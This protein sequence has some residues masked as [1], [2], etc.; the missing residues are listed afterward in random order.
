MTEIDRIHDK[1]FK[2]TFSNPDNVRTFLNAA[3]PESIRKAIDFSNIEIDFTDYV[4]QRFK[5][6]FSDM[7]ARTTMT[8][9]EEGKE[10]NIDIY[11]LF[12]HKSYRDAAIF[13]QLLLSMYLMW[14]KDMAENKPLRVIIPLV[15][16]HGRKSWNIPRSFAEQFNVSDE[17]KEFLLDYRY[18]LFDTR[19]W[20]FRKAKNKELGENVFLLSALALMKSIADDNLDSIVE[21]FKFWHEKGFTN[22]E[23]I[24][25][26]LTYISETKDIEPKEV[27]EM[28]EKVRI[29][30]GDIMPTLA[31]RFRDEGRHEGIKEGIKEEKLET[32]R[33]MLHDDFPIES[34]IKYTGLTEKE[35][36]ALIN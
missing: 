7:V 13:I 32:A 4:S 35:I 11:I 21:V 3:L 12:E 5:E 8:S 27:K 30:G 34:I 33:R 24:L 14:E 25:F 10:I 31:Q 16:Y 20:D 17:I 36:R 29:E 15:F 23:K 28:L 22:K 26:F 6:H 9:A 19:P 2:N 18:V 1:F